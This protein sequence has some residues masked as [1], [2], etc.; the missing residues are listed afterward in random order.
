MVT[1]PKPFAMALLELGMENGQSAHYLELLDSLSAVYKENPE[2]SQLLDAPTVDKKQKQEI[3]KQLFG[4][5][6]DETML[7]FFEILNQYRMAG[8]IEAI[9]KDYTE[10]YNEAND[11]EE[12]KVTSASELDQSQIEQLKEML[13]K[14]LNKQVVLNL[15]VDPSLIAGLKIET[16]NRT[17]DGSYA[18]RLEKMKEQLHKA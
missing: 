1:S 7:N 10:L 9:S 15:N 3:I 2:L 12:V 4:D 8:K 6:L 16:K 5:D 17:L 14:K 18:G 11:I 13:A